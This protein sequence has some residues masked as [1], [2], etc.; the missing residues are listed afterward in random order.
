MA[1]EKGGAGAE[2]RLQ[3]GQRGAHNCP[4]SSKPAVNRSVSSTTAFS[5]E[6]T[7]APP[8]P[9]HVALLRRELEAEAAPGLAPV[10]E[11]DLARHIAIAGGILHDR[12]GD[13]AVLC[14]E[15]GG[16]RE[17]RFVEA[18]GAMRPER[19]NGVLTN[20]CKAVLPLRRMSAMM[21]PWD[22]VRRGH[23]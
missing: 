4:V 1:P 14:G 2:G 3:R 10:A 18:R 19:N 7:S 9:R 6:A 22:A 23:S 17:Q 12:R 15:V 20:G 13:P 11:A 21:M 16:R 8:G 5:A